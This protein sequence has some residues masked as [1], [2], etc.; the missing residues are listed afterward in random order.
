MDIALPNGEQGP[1]LE[2]PSRESEDCF[3]PWEKST[4]RLSAKAK[5]LG[6]RGVSMAQHCP[7]VG[8]HQG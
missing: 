4:E 6:H 2:P 7:A 8:C 1:W 5:A 3:R